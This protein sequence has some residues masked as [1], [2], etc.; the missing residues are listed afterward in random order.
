M[1]ALPSLSHTDCN[2]CRLAWAERG[3]VARVAVHAENMG[4]VAEHAA[5][6]QQPEHVQG[7]AVGPGVFAGADQLRILEETAVLDRRIDAGQVLIN[8][9][10][11]AQVH[12]PDLGIAHLPVRQAHVAAFGMDQRVRRGG[13]QA[14]PVGQ[15]GLGQCIVG[16]ILAV[17]PTI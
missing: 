8:D 2:A 17:P 13:Q 7:T 3:G 15:C 6:R 14:L 1:R 11:G 9:T 10:A 5:R 16:R 12:V 4:L